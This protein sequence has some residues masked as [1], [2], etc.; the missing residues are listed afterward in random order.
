MQ[1]NNYR[2][3]SSEGV[4]PTPD[5]K[6]A[7][8][9][10]KMEGRSSSNQTRESASMSE[11]EVIDSDLTTKASPSPEADLLNSK[12]NES[13]SKPTASPSPEVIKKAP[14]A[15]KEKPR[16]VAVNADEEESKKVPILPSAQMT[17]LAN[18]LQKG[19]LK[20]KVIEYTFQLV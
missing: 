19:P 17:S 7:D 4:N 10:T 15:V 9:G 1:C 6:V 16:K 13:S 14:P 20:S 3:L 2:T 8:S 18:V 5:G 12:P 11:W